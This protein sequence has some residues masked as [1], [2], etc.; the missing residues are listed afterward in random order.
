[1]NGNMVDQVREK[2]VEGKERR[3]EEEVIHRVQIN[4]A[5]SSDD[6]YQKEEKE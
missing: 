1:M 5:Q 2:Q 4:A 6:E 3:R